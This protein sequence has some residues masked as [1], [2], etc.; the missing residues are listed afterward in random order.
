MTATF[1]DLLVAIH[2]SLFGFDGQAALIS[3]LA[4]SCLWDLQL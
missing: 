1:S 2:Q 4:S 3:L